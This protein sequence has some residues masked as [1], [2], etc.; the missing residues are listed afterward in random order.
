MTKQNNL[1]AV[2]G[3]SIVQLNGFGQGY[4][5]NNDGFL[6]DTIYIQ[7]SNYYQKY[8]YEIVAQRMMKTYED[9]VKKMIHPTGL[10]MFGRFA[11]KDAQLNGAAVVAEQSFSQL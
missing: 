11:I 3:K 7:D 2:T 8:S 9:Y 4:W 1:T 10:K 5:T 6:S